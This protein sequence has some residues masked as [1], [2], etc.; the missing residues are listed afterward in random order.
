MLK[1]E[2]LIVRKA[3]F[4]P[5]AALAFV[6]FTTHFGGGFASGRQLVEFYTR[7]GWYAA[8]LPIIAMA[9]CAI[10]F[11]YG[12][13]F[14]A[15]HRTFNYYSWAEKYYG[16][17]ALAAVYEI[18]YVIALA[19]ASAVAFATGGET[20]KALLGTPYFVN[21]IF[22]AILIFVLTI[23]GAETVRKAAASVSIVIII[24]LLIVLGSNFIA[25]FEA[26]AETIRL[27]KTE[28]NLAP[29]VWQMLLYAA[30]QTVVIGAYVSVAEPITTR[31]EA[32]SAALFGFFINASMITLSSLC[33]LGYYPDIVTEAVP[34][35]TVA[36][37]S[38]GGEIAAFAIS[39]LILLGVVSTG[40]NVV[41]A[42][43]KRIVD[44]V[45]EKRGHT[46]EDRRTNI[47]ASAGYVVLTWGIALFGLIPLVA[48][49]Y[50]YLGY[51][52]L[53]VVVLPVI[54]KGLLTSHVWFE[55]EV[56]EVDEFL[57][58]GEVVQ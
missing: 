23:F 52:G 5:T 24:G 29:A 54:G 33:L 7:F 11:Y 48:K 47:L 28:A 21:T 22:I 10:T 20:I 4:G 16:S 57:A 58:K 39:F 25:N 55:D 30:F 37:E 13:A 6:W 49:G 44:Y 51:I 9:I 12:W 3:L 31:S 17:K 41:Y 36:G 14:A 34:N 32:K 1:K 2:R 8:C 46:G 42:G 53:F 26:I 18:A 15:A 38:L 27:A 19:L 50:G 45:G 43:A 40:V 56:D 35:L